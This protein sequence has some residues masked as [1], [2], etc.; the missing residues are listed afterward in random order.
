[1]ADVGR[2]FWMKLYFIFARQQHEAEK[3]TKKTST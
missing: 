2:K 1:M 3:E